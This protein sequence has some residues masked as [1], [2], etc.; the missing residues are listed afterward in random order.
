ME[1]QFW[2]KSWELEGSYTSFHRRDIH[3]YALK[4]LP[5][6][7]LIG[8]TV[9][10]P[11]CGK[12]LDMLYFSKYANRVVGI[13]IVEKAVLQFF[14]ENQLPYRKIGNRYVCGNMTI[15]CD[16]LFELSRQDPDLR[17]VDIVYDRASLV[18]LPYDMRMQYLRKMEELTPVGALYFL[19]TLEYSPTLSTPP[20]SITPLET[21]SYFLN[22]HIE[23]VEQPI[24]PNHGMVRK[25]NL[26]YLIEHGY[27]MQKLYDTYSV[28][29]LVASEVTD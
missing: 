19:N 3:P 6:T 22:Y 8:K 10:V 27:V 1:Q 2:F 23:H 7:D 9:F 25:F 16:D 11:L 17:H 5:P 15:I 26:D 4:H 18:A 24:L 20:F 29:W 14:D 28:E 21:Q 12:T 13:E